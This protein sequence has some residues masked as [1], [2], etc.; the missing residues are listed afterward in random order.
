MVHDRQGVVA[1]QH[2]A[3]SLQ[4]QGGPMNAEELREF[5]SHPHFEAAV[6][7]RRYDDMGKVPEMET[8]EF[9]SFRPFL[10]LFVRVGA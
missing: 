10:K 4:L 1:P 2:H 5:E 3:R 8:P 6:R 9:E 7:L